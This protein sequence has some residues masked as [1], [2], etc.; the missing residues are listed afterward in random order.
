MLRIINKQNLSNENKNKVNYKNIL[1]LAALATV[2]CAAIA[3]AEEKP[4]KAAELDKAW[5]FDTSGLSLDP[6]NWSDVLKG[7]LTQ[8]GAGVAY[9][10]SLSLPVVQILISRLYLYALVKLNWLLVVL[11]YTDGREMIV[12][13]QQLDSL[14]SIA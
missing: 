11:R 13:F 10:A 3:K 7:K 1:V 8:V 4:D 5:K 9:A 6:N 2:C 12:F 14:C